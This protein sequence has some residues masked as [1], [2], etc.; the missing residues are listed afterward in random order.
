[1]NFLHWGSLNLKLQFLLF[2]CVCVLVHYLK[3]PQADD[4]GESTCPHPVTHHCARSKTI[5]TYY[6]G[7]Q[8]QHTT[9][10]TFYNANFPLYPAM[11]RPQGQQKLLVTHK[12][13][14]FTGWLA[15]TQHTH[16]H[17]HHLH[18]SLENHKHG[19][20]LTQEDIV[21]SEYYLCMCLFHMWAKSVW[22]SSIHTHTKDWR[23]GS[24]A[25]KQQYFCKT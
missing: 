16:T 3:L 15:P 20:Y 21:W 8:Q 23:M 4:T 12:H 10:A 2:L 11:K 6:N 14:P 24:K 13:T 5:S 7:Q 9:E 17:S 25:N 19:Y 1:M 18:F 22:A